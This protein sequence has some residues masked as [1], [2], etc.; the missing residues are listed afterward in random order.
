MAD[1]VH[2]H[3]AAARG[4]APPSG[5][6]A[7]RRGQNAARGQGNAQDLL[8]DAGAVN[9]VQLGI[10]QGD[11]D[12]GAGVSSVGHVDLFMWAGSFFVRPDERHLTVAR[13]DTPYSQSR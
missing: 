8:A 7:C 13:L 11:G 5:H 4:E 2:E 9:G 6:D 3:V 12:F 1:A 10:G